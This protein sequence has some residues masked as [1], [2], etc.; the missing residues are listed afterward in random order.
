[1]NTAIELKEQIKVLK[2]QQKVAEKAFARKQKDYKIFRMLMAENK[3]FLYTH[4]C[5]GDFTCFEDLIK[6]RGCWDNEVFSNVEYEFMF[7]QLGYTDIDFFKTFM[8]WTPD[9]FSIPFEDRKCPVCLDYY[10]DKKKP[11]KF[12]NCSHYCCVPCS[13]QL[14]SVGGYKCC[15]M[16]RASEK[17]K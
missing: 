10:T 7:K 3:A 2:E 8:S 17:P 14:V 5:E 16:C 4:L 13:K 11:R 1:M 6:A 12:A 9:I 15:V